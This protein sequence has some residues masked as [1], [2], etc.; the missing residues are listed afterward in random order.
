MHRNKILKPIQ[1]GE[2]NCFN[3]GT[4]KSLA[5]SENA[6]HFEQKLPLL[7]GLTRGEKAILDDRTFPNSEAKKRMSRWLD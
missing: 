2:R 1:K 6:D 4:L 7:E 3:H 5:N